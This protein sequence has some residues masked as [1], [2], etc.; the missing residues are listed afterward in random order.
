[1]PQR[2]DDTDPVGHCQAVD[3]QAGAVGDPRLVFVVAILVGG[4]CRCG[5]YH[6]PSCL[7]L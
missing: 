2:S 7:H 5:R 4:G 1:M 6:L 3:L